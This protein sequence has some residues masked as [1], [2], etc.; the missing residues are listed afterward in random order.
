MDL[1]SNDWVW[2]KTYRTTLGSE[3]EIVTS[4]SVDPSG[5][6][7]VAYASRFNSAY[8]ENSYIFVVRASDGGRLSDVTNIVHGASN[9]GNYVAE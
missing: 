5:A 2:R 1:L 7:V 4:L 6:K 8:D 9:Y 3:M